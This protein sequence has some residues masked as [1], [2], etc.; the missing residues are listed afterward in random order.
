M[1]PFRTSTDVT[2]LLL[3]AQGE[4]PFVFDKA[5]RARLRREIGRPCLASLERAG[6]DYLVFR[7]ADSSTARRKARRASER[8]RVLLYAVARALSPLAGASA[9]TDAGAWQACQALGGDAVVS[10]LGAAAARSKVLSRAIASS[11]PPGPPRLHALAAL[12][13]DVRDTLARYGIRGHRQ[14]ALAAEIISAVTG[15]RTTDPLR[16]LRA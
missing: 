12:K 10:M 9:K 4:R 1:R 14:T 11:F 13:R 6:G 3:A 5:M 15:K 8:E 2:R 7:A 16:S